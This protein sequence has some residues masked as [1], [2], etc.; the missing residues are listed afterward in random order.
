MGGKHSIIFDEIKKAVANIAKINY[1][2]PAKHTQVKCDASHSGLGATF[3]QN[4]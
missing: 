3:E 4:T 2:N 1:Y